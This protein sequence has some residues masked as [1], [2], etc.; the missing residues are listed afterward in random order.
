VGSSRTWRSCEG[1]TCL[2]VVYADSLNAVS[3]SDY[4]FVDHPGMLQALEASID[5][6]AA[7]PCDILI[8][9]HPDRIGFLEKAAGRAAGARNPIIDRGACKAYADAARARLGD[10]LRT[11]RGR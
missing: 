4:R 8:A 6:V 10:R 3:G 11:E 1:E 7:L 2:D 9:P 5:R